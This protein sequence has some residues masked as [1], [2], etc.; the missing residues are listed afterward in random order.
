MSDTSD[1][2][3]YLMEH[4]ETDTALDILDRWM[5]EIYDDLIELY[6]EREQMLKTMDEI[7]DV[8]KREGCEYD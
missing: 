8:I 1:L 6:N 7:S 3:Y 4:G 5:R 2:I